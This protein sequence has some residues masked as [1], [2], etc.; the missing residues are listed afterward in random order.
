MDKERLA[1]VALSQQAFMIATQ[2]RLLNEPGLTITLPDGKS[3][4]AYVGEVLPGGFA[5]F[6]KEKAKAEKAEA[7]RCKAAK[8]LVEK[9]K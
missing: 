7:E 9:H 6:A 1:A 2:M 4:K 5:G 3:V 8:E